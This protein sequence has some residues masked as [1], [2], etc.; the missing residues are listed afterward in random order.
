LAYEKK[1][2]RDRP[3]ARE[4]TVTNWR[5]LRHAVGPATR[6]PEQTKA[7]ASA[8]LPVRDQATKA[9][10]ETLVR[11]GET[12]P[13]AAAALELLEPLV[14]AHAAGGHR[15]AWVLGEVFAAGHLTRLSGQPPKAS[16]ERDAVSAR[17]SLARSALLSALGSEDAAWRSG[18][19]FALS[20]VPGVDAESL[21]GAA[22]RE[23]EPMARVSL[24]LALG[25]LSREDEAARRVLSESFVGSGDASGAALARAIGGEEV[26]DR[27]LADA[28]MAFCLAPPAQELVPWG[29]LGGATRFVEAIVASAAHRKQMA[30]ALAEALVSPPR[31]RKDPRRPQ[32]AKLV[33]A[34]AGIR[35][36][37]PAR[38]VA[39]VESLA[40]DLRRIAVAF[41][42]D[43]SLG[44]AETGLAGNAR[45]L[46]RWLGEIPPGPLESLG[47]NGEPR[48]VVARALIGAGK[49]FADALAALMDGLTGRAR[50]DTLTELLRGAYR[51]TWDAQGRI[52][53]EM[54]AE[55]AARMGDDAV[56]WAR[57]IV[58]EVI[59]LPEGIRDFQ[60]L[61]A[62]ASDHLMVALQILVR[63]GA[64]L[65]AG[66]EGQ[67]PINH[68]AAREILA[69]LPGESVRRST[70][71]RW[72]TKGSSNSSA[73]KAFIDEVMPL[74]DA[75]GSAALAREM[76]ADLGGAGAKP[77]PGIA[78]SVIETLSRLSTGG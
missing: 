18:A 16:P 60:A 6:V 24:L 5:E 42:T 62:F 51:M 30:P 53:P 15:A 48:W 39:R 43:D 58:H 57:D 77:P 74:F 26:G 22:R 2:D 46:R 1:R 41:A 23:S 14:A 38:H 59:G 35:E 66:I 52:S 31:A 49:P 40:S 36:T 29:G 19:A 50:L 54:L 10:A 27:A 28:I 13:A 61:S 45:A 37:Y 7:L 76:L 69:A 71:E 47:P 11:D 20:F 73:Q 4:F 9:L 33:L 63:A 44:V 67:V 32:L 8:D 21:A 12:F 75:V 55:E 34:W 68:P 64:S 56:A 70:L 78:P 25:V 17:A 65:E 3:C 72:R